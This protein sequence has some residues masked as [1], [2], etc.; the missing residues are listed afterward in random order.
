MIPSSA[1]VHPVMPVVVAPAVHSWPRRAIGVPRLLATIVASVG[2][3]L[4]LL[5]HA[6][7]S[8]VDIVWDSCVGSGSEQS[9]KEFLCSG[10]MDRSYPLICQFRSP[11]SL[12]S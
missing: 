6:R 12:N 3:L 1:V 11:V 8:G 9:N 7:A 4:S 5:G 10:F 2:I